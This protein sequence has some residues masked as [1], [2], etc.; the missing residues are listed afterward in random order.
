MKTLKVPDVSRIV[1]YASHTEPGQDIGRDEIYQAHIKEGGAE[2]GYHY[3]VRRCGRIE[4]G[5]PL[6]AWGIAGGTA[7]NSTSI[8]ICLIGGADYKGDCDANWTTDQIGSLRVLIHNL[9][10]IYPEAIPHEAKLT[11][12][13]LEAINTEEQLEEN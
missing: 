13:A 11:L 4:I 7:L 3:V 1:L 8:A 9:R 5:T 6:P 12:G 2:C 10:L